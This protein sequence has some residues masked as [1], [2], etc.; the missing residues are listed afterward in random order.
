MHMLQP[1]A[2]MLYSQTSQ[3]ERDPSRHLKTTTEAIEH[4]ECRSDSEWLAMAE[5]VHFS[6]HLYSQSIAQPIH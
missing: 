1:A 4:R 5:C 3:L 6:G 2:D